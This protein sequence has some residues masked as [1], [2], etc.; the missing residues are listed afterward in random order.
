[1]EA[2]DKGKFVGAL[3]DELSVQQ[4]VNEGDSLGAKLL[5]IKLDRMRELAEMGK[6]LG[7]ENSDPIINRKFDAQKEAAEY[8][9]KI[10]R[11]NVAVA[12]SIAR[13]RGSADDE[14]EQSLRLQLNLARQIEMEARRAGMSAEK[15]NELA[16]NT[17]EKEKASRDFT[18][19]RLGRDIDTAGGVDQSAMRADA[20]AARAGAYANPEAQTRI[21]LDAQERILENQ[22]EKIREKRNLDQTNKQL[23]A[24]ERQILDQISMVE[25][26][27]WETAQKIAMARE[28][29]IREIQTENSALK[30]QMAGYGYLAELAKMHADAQERIRDAMHVGNTDLAQQI[31]LQEQLN[32][33]KLWEEHFHH[34]RTQTQVNRQLRIDR[35][36]A[37][38][39]ERENRMYDRSG[40]WAAV[41]GAAAIIGSTN[42][43]TAD[44]YRMNRND[45]EKLKRENS[46][47]T[48]TAAIQR[49][50]EDSNKALSEANNYLK[51]IAE[52]EGVE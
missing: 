32:A 43:T 6:V 14:Q 11:Q 46:A 30:L 5:Q 4:K 42:S 3:R 36:V 45:T 8:D 16:K 25:S 23:A 48:H 2:K 29:E 33:K 52:K 27:R 17:A 38:Q 47:T 34:A 13:L 1:M 39:R 37:R 22:L 7:H 19:A 35:I 18:R 12:I 26:Q 51:T 31:A 28:K 49:V 9:A 10:Q 50:L 21:E 41:P 40:G 20:A 24:E 44:I 15:I